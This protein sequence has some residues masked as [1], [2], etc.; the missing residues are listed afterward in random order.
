MRGTIPTRLL[1]GLLL[2]GCCL[3]LLGGWSQ[4]QLL[5]EDADGYVAHAHSLLQTGSF[6]GPWTGRPTAFRPPL[7]PLI[8]S[9]PIA[10]GLAPAA[11]VLLIQIISAVLCTL[12]GIRLAARMNFGFRGSLLIGLAVAMDPLLL[13]YSLQPMTETLCAAV[14]AWGLL[15]LPDDEQTA[16]LRTVG[17]S[18]RSGSAAGLVF[19]AG[20]LLRPV[21]LIVAALILLLETAGMLRSASEPAA[22]TDAPPVADCRRRRWATFLLGLLLI[23]TP[24]IV[25]NR[26][27]LG[28]WVIATTHGGYTL[29][30]GNNPEFYRDVIVG[31]EGMPWNGQA[32]DRWQQASLEQAAAAGVNVGDEVLLDGWYYSHAVRSMKSDP[33]S[34]CA[35]CLLRMRRFW[36]LSSTNAEGWSVIVPGVWYLFLWAG[37]LL[38]LVSGRWRQQ[39]PRWCWLSV[40][41]FCL[42]HLVYWT[43]T[44][45]RA[46]LMPILILLSADGYRW[47]TGW[48][49]SAAGHDHQN[50]PRD[51]D[52]PQPVRRESV[53]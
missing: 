19:G 27:V 20:V 36:A 53:P 41:G 31:G 49:R 39:L 25:R 29:A 51:Q 13:R 33:Q 22:A 4:P 17:R 52:V 21:I 45:M 7:L 2:W 28:S 16:G 11:A 34:F 8:L 26:L 47:C 15:L 37:L 18:R 5:S 24:W 43:D 42:L 48:F 3:R 32:L 9:V 10:A 14:L 23:V 50:A 30:L 40:L 44:R 46:P 12:A 6:S 38:Q 1:W 35:A